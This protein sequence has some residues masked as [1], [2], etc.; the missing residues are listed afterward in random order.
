MSYVN[1]RAALEIALDGVLP[2][3]QTAWDNTPLT[4]VAGVPYQRASLVMAQPNNQEY[5]RNYQEIGT[6]MIG[7]HYPEGVGSSELNA[8]YE[9]LRTVFARGSSFVNSG[10]IVTVSNTP[11]IS[12]PFSDADMYVQT[13]KVPFYSNQ[14]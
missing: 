9:Q 12:P 2:A 13:V 8:R 4:P 10:T 6:L 7:L 3:L 1:V 14:Y 11:S 5:G